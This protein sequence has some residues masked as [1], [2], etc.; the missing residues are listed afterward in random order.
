MEQVGISSKDELA[1]R[2]EAVLQQDIYVNRLVAENVSI[3]DGAEE[4]FY[5]RHKEELSP[6]ERLRVR[7]VFVSSLQN[8]DAAES[9]IRKV[10]VLHAGGSSFDTLAKGYSE[11]QNSK[12]K[13]GDLGWLSKNRCPK[14]FLPL[15]FPED[16]SSRPIQAEV[17]QSELGWHL[18]QVTEVKPAEVLP[19]E[20]L[21][22]EITRAM[23]IQSYPESVKKLKDRIRLEIG[24]RRRYIDSSKDSVSTK[25]IECRIEI[26]E[27]IFGYPLTEL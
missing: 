11:D 13:G 18:M 9:K 17:L 16:E 8:P 12:Q 24:I 21:S 6:K 14:E 25:E 3:A 10:A 22:E 1:L 23:R 15:L 19:F 4:A 7:H 26:F 5:E 2:L 27:D 20:Q